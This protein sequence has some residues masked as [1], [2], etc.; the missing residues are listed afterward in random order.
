MGKTPARKHSAK[1]PSL[2][3]IAAGHLDEG[4][5]FVHPL[6]TISLFQIR[7]GHLDEC[8]ISSVAG[9]HVSGSGPDNN[10]TFT[11][12]RQNYKRCRMLIASPGAMIFRLAPSQ[13]FPGSE[14]LVKLPTGF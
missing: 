4:I 3:N 5:S 6:R 1:L 10:F 7:F 14:P 9:R 11:R 2:R 13:G 12:T 8:S